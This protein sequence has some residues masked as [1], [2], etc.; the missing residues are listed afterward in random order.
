MPVCVTVG[1]SLFS[2]FPQPAI[3]SPAL[4]KELKNRSWV[5]WSGEKNKGPDGW[6]GPFGFFHQSSG[7]NFK[8][9]MLT[10]WSVKH[11]CSEGATLNRYACACK[12]TD[13]IEG[14][15][16]WLAHSLYLKIKVWWHRWGIICHRQIRLIGRFLSGSRGRVN[17]KVVIPLRITT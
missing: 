13:K 11:H 9:S 16:F 17:N 10:G 12:L 7:I 8:A 1:L 15:W 3:S 2:L 14:A 5:M 6:S 4:I